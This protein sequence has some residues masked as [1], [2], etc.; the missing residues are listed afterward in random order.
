MLSSNVLADERPGGTAV[1]A[2]IRALPGGSLQ[3]VGMRGTARARGWVAMTPV[4][5]LV[6]NRM[7]AGTGW[8]YAGPPWG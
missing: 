5:C 3:E 4:T 6:R 8:C 1:P 2:G 7:N